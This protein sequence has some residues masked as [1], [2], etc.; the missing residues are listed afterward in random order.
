MNLLKFADMECHMKGTL[1]Y[2]LAGIALVSAAF[3][4]LKLSSHFY[5]VSAGLLGMGIV[6]FLFGTIGH[7]YNLDVWPSTTE[8]FSLQHS[9]KKT[10]ESTAYVSLKW[11]FI[12]VNVL[13]SKL[14][15]FE[16]HELNNMDVQR[17]IHPDDFKN[18]FSN[19]QKLLAGQLTSYQ[20]LQRYLD[21]NGDPLVL[22]VNVTLARD[23]TGKPLYFIFAFQKYFVQPFASTKTANTV[24]STF[25]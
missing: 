7:L 9:L 17:F 11:R 2:I 14:L 5:V 25:A 8:T 24:Y 12:K 18:N 20:S 6:I 16:I 23:S 21:K 10:T 1:Y 4:L 22:D 15:G 3:F 13:F 19:I